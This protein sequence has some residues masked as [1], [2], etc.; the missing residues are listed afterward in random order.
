MD[1][2]GPIRLT[3]VAELGRG[4]LDGGWWPYTGSIAK[5]LPELIEALERPLGPIADIAV[6]WGSLEGVPDLDSLHYRGNAAVRSRNGRPQRVMT[7]TGSRACARLLVVPCQT[8][9]ALAVM[10]LRQAAGLPILSAHRDT[11]AFRTADDIVCAARTEHPMF[12]RSALG[13]A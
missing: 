5:E 11:E 1:H 2:A 9:T 4:A 13:S 12:V 7:V 8:S 3:L 6:N 10:L